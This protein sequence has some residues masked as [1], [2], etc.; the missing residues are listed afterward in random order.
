MSFYEEM[1]DIAS[2]LLTEFKQGVIEYAK[3]TPGTGPADNPGPATETKYE[4]VGAVARGVSFKYV[5]NGLALAGDS[6]V[7]MNVD[8]RFGKPTMP[9]FIDKDGIR[10]TIVQVV[11]I[12]DAGTAVAYVVIIRR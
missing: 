4:L 2:S 1:Q 3:L 5:Q 12:P 8:D 11:A 6:Q 10:Y 7:T 9:G